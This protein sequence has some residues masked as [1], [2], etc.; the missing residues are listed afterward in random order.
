MDKLAKVPKENELPE[1]VW[2]TI[3][4]QHETAAPAEVY[5]A[6]LA[7]TG[8]YTMQRKLRLALAALSGL[9]NVKEVPEHAELQAPWHKLRYKHVRALRTALRKRGLA[10]ATINAT[11]SAV[12]GVVREAFRLGYVSAED[13]ERIRTVRSVKGERLPKGRA[14][15][16]GELEALIRACEETEDGR[17]PGGARDAAMLALMYVAGLRRAEV[18][19]LDLEDYD[20]DTGELRVRGKGNRERML[21]ANDGTGDAVA[22]WLTFRGREPGALFL[23]LRRGGHVVH[24]QKGAPARLTTQAVYNVLKARAEVAGVTKPTPHDIRRTFISHLL[25]AGADISVVQKLAGHR[26]IE[27]TARYD[28]RG[29]EAKKKAVGLLHVPYRRRHHPGHAVAPDPGH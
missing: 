23:P 4:G 21:Y 8:R 13:Y 29:E 18:V 28:M 5:L 25:E 6:G 9:A 16:H 19:A 7:D 3:D 20:G 1:V 24:E 26:Q 10:P 17:V 2:D 12:R 11:L 15:S 14:L 22:D 27:T